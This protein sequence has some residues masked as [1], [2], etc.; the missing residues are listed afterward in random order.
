MKNNK[1]TKKLIYVEDFLKALKDEG[2]DVCEVMGEFEHEWGFS[3]D[4]IK[5]ALEMTPA[6][7]AIPLEEHIDEVLG[8]DNRYEVLKENFVD[9]VCSGTS[10]VAPYCANKCDECVDGRGWCIDGSK[11]CRGFNPEMEEST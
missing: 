9:Y 2:V 7:S 3:R 6:A 8:W 5:K 1:T 10:N 4:I 11:N